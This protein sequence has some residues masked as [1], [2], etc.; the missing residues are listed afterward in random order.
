ILFSKKLNKYYIGSTKDIRQ[1]KKLPR[2][3]LLKAPAISCLF[4]IF[5]VYPTAM[6]A[7]LIY[8]VTAF[9]LGMPMHAAFAQSSFDKPAFYAVMSA[10]DT[11]SIN[12]QLKKAGALP[13]IEKDAFTGALLMKKAGLIKGASYKLNLFKTGRKKLEAAIQENS[14]SAELR[15]LRLMIQ[16]HAPGALGYK[17]DL[18]RDSEFIKKNYRALPLAVQQAVI[19][20]SKTSKTLS[21]SD[22]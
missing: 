14:S 11:F 20:Y 18:Q 16:E 8:F 2:P 21:H 17:S 4:F 1:R 5:A 19:S 22:F 3:S 7:K 15:F 10:N 13:I 9:A 12:E 6:S